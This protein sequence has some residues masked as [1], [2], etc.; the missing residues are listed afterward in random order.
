MASLVATF[1]LVFSAGQLVN[2]KMRLVNAADAAAYS[3]AA[4]EARSLNYQS[5]LNRAIVANE[6][7]LAQLVSLRSWSRHIAST[8]TNTSRVAQFIPPLA[9]PMRALAQGW[10]A[11][12]TSVQATLPPLEAALSSWNVA[13]LAN[14]Q[15]L[16]HQ[17]AAIVAADLVSDVAQ[18][19]EPRAQV[20]NATRLLQVRNASAWQNRFTDRYRR[21]SGDL[22]RIT[23][24]L[25]DSRDGFTRSRRTDLPVVMPLVQVPK[26]GG[27]DLLGEYSWRGVDSMSVHINLLL[28]SV[29]IP[30]GWGAAEQQ[31]VAVAQRGQHGG[32]LSRNP[33]ASRLAL[34]ALRPARGY[35]G[36][37]EVRD[38]VT[39]SRR[40]ERTLR[41]AVALRL[42]QDRI[43]TADRLLMPQGLQAPDGS[44][45]SLVP[46]LADG[47]LHAL[48]AAE[49]FH[50]RPDARRDGRR[51]YASLFNPYWQVRL[52]DVSAAERTLTAADR[53]LSVDPYAT[54]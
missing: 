29:E 49:V 28:G 26:R 21:G 51:E 36:V 2:D 15:S 14:A 34:R 40:D 9:G 48:A 16:A 37:P 53:G 8:T 44:A 46:S 32:S 24:L 22:R 30:V 4:W 47:A 23:T 52:V 12:D 13:V 5:Y 3:A 1:A 41:Y 42:P 20:T 31:R 17:Q 25:M 27:T 43:A 18:A 19:N 45:H 6:V 39:P 35:Q 7:A 10:R 33:A 11:V 54:P 50:Q 38:V